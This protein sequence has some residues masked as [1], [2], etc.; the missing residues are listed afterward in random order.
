MSISKQN[1]AIRVAVI[2]DS[3]ASIPEHVR[4]AAGVNVVNLHVLAGAQSFQENVDITPTE[5]AQLIAQKK[6]LTTSQPTRADFE[7]ALQQAW[8]AGFEEAVLVLISSALSG[9]VSTARTV[10][11]ASERTVQVV[12]SQTSGMA[13]GFAAVA[14]GRA[15]AGGL[16]ADEVAA[17]AALAA[18]G[19]GAYFLVD[20]LDHLRRG[21]RLGAAA[22]ALGT[23]LGLKPILTIDDSGK[24]VVSS[25]VRS[26]A[27]ALGHLAQHARDAVEA[28][29]SGIAVHYF[30]E[31]DRARALADELRREVQVPVYLSSASAV[32]GSH[33]GPGL[34]AVTFA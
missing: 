14:A 24:I 15:A 26:R 11:E 7:R 18:A 17:A 3:T 5:C 4:I 16:S 9:T 32:L 12:D 34:V 20:S 22:A 21:G 2:T 19:S 10:A 13:L 1:R 30:G 23:L 8:D 28:G 6:P 33:V 25:K 31:P 27:A 29:A